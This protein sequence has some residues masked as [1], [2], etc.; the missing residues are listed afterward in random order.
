MIT[1]VLGGILGAITQLLGFFVALL[2]TV[3]S[4]LLELAVQILNAVISTGLISLSYT[5]P[6]GNPFIAVGW[7]AA[8]VEA[9]ERPPK[10]S[11]FEAMQELKSF[12][13][14]N[15]NALTHLLIVAA[16][17]NIGSTVATFV[18]LPFIISM[19]A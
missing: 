2:G 9:R 16:Y 12:K 7:V 11:D 4:L 3:T 19:L 10:V 13:D 8:M 6:A 18:V 17:T 1:A 14:F 5:N 15:K